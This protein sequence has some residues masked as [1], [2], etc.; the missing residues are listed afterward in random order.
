[1]P[2]PKHSDG[3]DGTFEWLC[4]AQKVKEKEPLHG[5][6]DIQTHK[7]PE[8]Q[9]YATQMRATHFGMKAATLPR[10]QGHNDFLKMECAQ[11]IQQFNPVQQMKHHPSL[12]KK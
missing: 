3:E 5:V 6:S 11:G 8:A 10:K 9:I 12:K 7:H 2:A 4:S 1:M